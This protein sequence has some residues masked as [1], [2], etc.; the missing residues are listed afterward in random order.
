MSEDMSEDLISRLL[1]RDRWIERRAR[2]RLAMQEAE[3]AGGQL[4]PIASRAAYDLT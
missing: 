4:I 1:R 2:E 3:T